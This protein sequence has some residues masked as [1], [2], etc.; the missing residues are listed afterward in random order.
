MAT[1]FDKILGRI[2]QQ[3]DSGGGGGS[4]SY[5]PMSYKGADDGV[6]ELDSSGYV[7]ESQLRGYVASPLSDSSAP[8]T[9]TTGKLGQLYVE[10]TTPALYLCYAVDSVTPSYSWRLVP[11]GGNY[12][13]LQQS[14]TVIT[15]SDD[16]VELMDG[17]VY[18]HIPAAATTY[19]LPAV[20]DTTKTHEI[21]LNVR[22]SAATISIAFEDSDSTTIVPLSTPVISAGSVVSYL[23]R[24][25]PLLEQWAIMPVEL[26][27]YT[28]PEEEEEEP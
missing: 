6:A 12:M 13:P 8:T 22:F 27:T 16:D 17:G 5:I 1:I 15:A 24:Y 23:C 7:P 26:G 18:S 11:N 21:I 28:E 10:T 20:S 14:I 2:R 9:A 3:D 19:T 25:E 4:G